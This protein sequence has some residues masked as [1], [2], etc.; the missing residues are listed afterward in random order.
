M[1]LH[2]GHLRVCKHGS[3]RRIHIQR[4]MVHR[5]LTWMNHVNWFGAMMTVATNNLCRNLMVLR[6]AVIFRTV[7]ILIGRSVPGDIFPNQLILFLHHHR[8]NR[9]TPSRLLML[10]SI[11]KG[12]RSLEITRQV[13][14]TLHICIYI[15]KLTGLFR[16]SRRFGRTSTS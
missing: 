15:S 11:K 10:F 1:L 4:V 3:S 9:M 8:L 13:I 7:M 5:S 14:S 16:S 6:M 2:L 12:A